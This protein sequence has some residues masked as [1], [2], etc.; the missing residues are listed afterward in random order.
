MGFRLDSS[1]YVLVQARPREKQDPN[2]GC[3][4]YVAWNDSNEALGSRSVPMIFSG[5]G[6]FIGIG[7]VP[8]QCL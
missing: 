6:K 1:G 5:V 8:V 4:L 7:G 3:E 2:E